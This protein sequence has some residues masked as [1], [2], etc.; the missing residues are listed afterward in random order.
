MKILE[1]AT[2]FEWYKI[3]GKEIHTHICP[4]RLYQR[5]RTLIPT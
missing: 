3:K 4:M 1:K 2:A 5:K